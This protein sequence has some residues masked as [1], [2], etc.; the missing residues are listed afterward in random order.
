MMYVLV[1]LS[2]NLL[3]ILLDPFFPCAFHCNAGGFGR[4]IEHGISPVGYLVKIGPFKPHSVPSHPFVC[5]GTIASLCWTLIRGPTWANDPGAGE[6]AE[7]GAEALCAPALLLS[8]L[9]FLDLTR[10][11][12][13]WSGGNRHAS[14][15]EHPTG[16]QRCW[17]AWIRRFN[18]ASYRVFCL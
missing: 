8:V 15:P 17:M 12:E 13:L 1:E 7:H 14:R 11:C 4:S 6:K 2:F 10:E 18:V 9:V 16:T 3:Y 5:L